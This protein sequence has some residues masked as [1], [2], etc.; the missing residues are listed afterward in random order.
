M[1]NLL[2]GQKHSAFTVSYSNI[3]NKLITEVNLYNDTGRKIIAK[4]LWDTGATTTCI[5]YNI[6]KKLEL[7]VFGKSHIQTP[8]GEIDVNTYLINIILPNDVEVKDVQVCDSAIGDQN[9]DVLIGMNIISQGDFS[10]SNY[11]GK[12]T[13]SFRTP[14]H[15]VIDFVKQIHTS[16]ILQR[17]H[18]TKKKKR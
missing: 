6:A 18:T 10:V 14:P 13:F 1:T 4:A 17:G 5:S 16:I 8:S 15:S 7:P 2:E 11:N 9:L 3:Q 12:T